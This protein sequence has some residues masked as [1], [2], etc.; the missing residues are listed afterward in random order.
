MRDHSS[1][2]ELNR[3]EAIR[4]LL[5]V[6]RFSPEHEIVPIEKAVGRVLAEDVFAQLDMPNCL[7]CKMDSVAVHWSDFENGMPDTTGWVKGVNWDFA[8][9]GVGM[10]EGFDTAITVEHVLLSDSD[11][12]IAFDALPSGKFAGTVPRGNNMKKGDL[13][14]AAGTVVTPLLA[15]HI[16]SGN[17]TEISVI[18]KPRVTF[19]PT[20]NELVKAPGKATASSVE[21][22]VSRG[23]NIETNSVMIS[24]KIRAWGGEP[25]CHE[26]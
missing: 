12:S 9:T 13:L 4:T 17:N 16:L 10:P 2:I 5:D 1:H 18:K 11:T 26:I 22:P 3:E 8:N 25:F 23:K 24:G 19:I 6:C 7:T 21:N 20:G 15:A 14:V